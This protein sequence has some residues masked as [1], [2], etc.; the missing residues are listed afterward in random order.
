[1]LHRPS[2]NVDQGERLEWLDRQLHPPGTKSRSSTFPYNVAADVRRGSV[3]LA[4]L[5]GRTPP[6]FDEFLFLKRA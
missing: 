5:F 1:V 2:G 4:A 3:E 6:L